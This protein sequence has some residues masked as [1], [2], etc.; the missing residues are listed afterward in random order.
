[1]NIIL[2]A[3]AL[4]RLLGGNT[5]LEIELRQSVVAQFAKHHLKPLINSVEVQSIVNDIKRH[6]A[7]AATASIADVETRWSGG[8]TVVLKPEIVSKIKEK[9]QEQMQS[10]IENTV[11]AAMTELIDSKF[12]EQQVNSRLD[13]HIKYEVKSQVDAKMAAIRQSIG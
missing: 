7:D 13:Y 12:I 9:T 3:S 6:A 11:R 2:D 1:M 4:D 8:T 10:I 5:E